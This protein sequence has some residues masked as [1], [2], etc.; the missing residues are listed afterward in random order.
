MEGER[1][2]D[3]LKMRV[4]S[5]EVSRQRCRGLD[6]GLRVV[7]DAAAVSG[8]KARFMDIKAHLKPGQ[9]G[10]KGGEVRLV[11]PLGDQAREIEIVLPGRY[12][13]SPNAAGRVSTVPGVVEV[14]EI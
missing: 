13:V 3:A 2:G 12:D 11:L 1:D 8:K 4:Q 9:N 6:Q 5:L 7:L 14:V 10:R